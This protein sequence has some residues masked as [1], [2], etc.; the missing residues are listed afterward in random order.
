VPVNVIEIE[1][2]GASVNLSVYSVVPSW[3]FFCTSS[4]GT[5]P[6]PV[7]SSTPLGPDQVNV[8][9]IINPPDWDRKHSLHPA[10]DYLNL[11]DIQSLF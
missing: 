10:S 6:T 8:I 11:L 9:I 3:V 5:P 4:C 7:Q 1:I 2:G